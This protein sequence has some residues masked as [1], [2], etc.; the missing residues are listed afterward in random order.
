MVVD[1]RPPPAYT[2]PPESTV[3]ASS[4]IY[5][6]IS[7]TASDASQRTL[8]TSFTIRPCSGQAWIVPAG[9]VCRLTTPKGP[10][11]GDLNIWNANNPRERLWAARTRQ[12]HASHVSVGDRL[13]SNLPYLRPLVTITGDSLG[14]G[15]LHEVLDA[16]GKRTKGFGTTQWGGR[17]HDLL[18]TRCDPYVNLLMGGESFDFHCHSN[19]T[20]SVLPYG[21]TELDVHDVLNVF[22]VTGLDEEGKYFMETS[23][24]RPGEY[25]EF[26]AEVDVLC[27]LS[28][29]P[30]GDLS[31]WGWEEKGENMGATT[32]PLGVEVYKLNDPKVLENW[33]EPESPN[34]V[35]FEAEIITEGDLA[36]GGDKS[37]K[38]A[39]P[40]RASPVGQNIN[41]YQIT[42]PYTGMEE[43]RDFEKGP[44]AQKSPE[45]DVQKSYDDIYNVRPWNSPLDRLQSAVSTLGEADE[46][47]GLRKP[48][49]YKQPQVFGG[50]MLLWLAYQSIGVIYGDIGTSPLYVYSSTFSEAPSRQD[51]IGVLSIIIWSL[52]MMVTVKYVLVI[53]RADNDGEGGTFST[54]SLLSRYM[55]ITNRDPREASLVQMKRHLTDELERTSRHVRHRLES[56][57]VAKRLLKVMGVL[58]VTM[59]L[60]DGLLTPAQSVLGAVQG[61]EVVSPNISKGTI[62]GVTDAILVVLFLIQPLGIT[63]LTFAF[64][65]IVI[66]WLGFNAAFGIYNLAKY[67]AGVFIAFNPGYAFSFLARHGE[68]GWRMLSGT[69]LAFTGVEALFADIGAFSRRAIQIS[70]LGYAFPC[71][72]LAYIGQAAYISVHPEAYSNPFFNAAPPGT[73]YPALVIAILAAVVASQAIITATFQIKVIHTSDIFHG[74]LYIPIAN[75]LLM[76][77][78]ILIASIYNNTTSLGNAYGVCVMFVTFFDTC[79]VSLAAMFVWRIS[80]FIVLF[81]WLIVACLDGAYLSSSLMKVPTGAWFTIALATVLAILFLIWRFGKEQQWFAEAEDRFPTSHFVSKDPDGQIRLTDR[82]GSTPLS[83]TKG[84]GIFFDKAGETTP[85]VFSQFIL[86][87]TTMPAVIIFFHLRPIETPSVPAEDRYTVSRLAIPNCYRLLVRYGYNDEII[88]PDLA[89]T[90]TQQVRRYLITRSCDQADPS[91]CTP[92]TITNKSHTSSVKQSTTSATGESSTVDGGR[93]DTSLTKLEDAYNHGVIYITG[94][95]QM[96]IKK[97]KNYFRRIVLW[98]FLWIRENTRAKIASL[99]LATEKVIEVG[100][101]KDI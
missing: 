20:R 6:A 56:S 101:L 14:G 73:V 85:I 12:I 63:K 99:G 35:A 55:N 72:L 59:V 82:Y 24:A 81:P 94:K 75:W 17:V 49:D 19:L 95:E 39:I 65:P 48:E 92:D 29:C 77:G 100:F 78:T 40:P 98:V 37:R 5:R 46:D 3:H 84:L 87:L 54:Y 66:I 18:G 13:W 44:I 80:P 68:E 34:I 69:L 43:N 26:F 1:R 25:F 32:R 60:A 28:A 83:I 41:P 52:F 88:T 27:A 47:P 36:I 79:M 4:E 86:K 51:L 8:E 89:N 58:A 64:A 21:L 30:G 15:Q 91:T 90:I 45:S 96:R 74:Q 62:I 70:W 76:V 11:V 42:A 2:A 23:P 10:Q 53:L 33:K 16:E 31:N 71:L 50:R 38:R 22:Q 67:D 97:S 57:S 93:Y 9:H 61:I 7:N